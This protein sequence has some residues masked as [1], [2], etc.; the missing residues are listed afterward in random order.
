MNWHLAAVFVFMLG[1]VIG[2]L[3]ALLLY[4]RDQRQ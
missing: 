3:L 4:L 2:L 1:M